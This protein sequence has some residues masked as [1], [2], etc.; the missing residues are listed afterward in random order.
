MRQFQ[1]ISDFPI[2]ETEGLEARI[3]STIIS[4]PTSIYSVMRVI[5]SEMFSSEENRR[6]WDTVMDMFN[7]HEVIDL[8]TVM[9]RVDRMHFINNILNVSPEAGLHGLQGLLGAFI[10]TYVKRM[11]YVTAIETLQQINSGRPSSDISSNFEGFTQRVCDGMKDNNTKSVTDIANDLAE[12]TQNGETNRVPTSFPSVDYLTYGGFNGGN[13]VILAARPSVGKTTIAMQ[14]AKNASMMGQKTLVC[15]LEMSAEE[16]VQRMILSTGYISPSEYFTKKFDWQ[17]YERAVGEVCNKNLVIN[18]KVGGVDELCQRIRVECQTGKCRF[19]II[20][21]LGLIPIT[22]SKLNTATALGEI[23][24]KLKTTAK[25]C[26]VPI[27]LLCQL[28]RSSV[29]ESRSP[30]LHDLRDSGAIEQDADIVIMLERTK[31]DMGVVM[32]NS[33]DLWV[34]KNRSGKCNF[35]NPIRL[36][37]NETYSNFVECNDMEE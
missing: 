10:D 35:D 14:I 15:S 31:D 4:D 11:A 12:K 17:Q 19:V 34:R 33:I 25:E 9:P 24:R 6:V 30:Q 22:N 13:L 29:S 23:T 3:L 5:K 18:D 28:N 26:N 16:L 7:G 20:D 21:Y 8:T 37:G 27:L 32:D 1:Q 36:R 2:P